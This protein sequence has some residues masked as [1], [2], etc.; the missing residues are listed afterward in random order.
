MKARASYTA[1]MMTHD[2]DDD[3]G[4]F[5]VEILRRIRGI[6]ESDQGHLDGAVRVGE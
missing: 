6:D 4:S 2:L 3:E 5:C 1:A